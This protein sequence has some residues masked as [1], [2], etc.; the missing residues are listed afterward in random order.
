MRSLRFSSVIAQPMSCERR[1]RPQIDRSFAMRCANSCRGVDILGPAE[2]FGPR[3]YILH[4]FAAR[5]RCPRC[6][7]G[8]FC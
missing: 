7:K 1:Y 6:A 4:G 2:Q 3:R 8:W 5:D